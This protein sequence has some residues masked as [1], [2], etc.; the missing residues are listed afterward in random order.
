MVGMP[1]LFSFLATDSFVGGIVFSLGDV[2]NE[3]SV[4]SS[5]IG[6]ED[7]PREGNGVDF[8]FA[9]GAGSITVPGGP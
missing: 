3:E 6:E 8:K 1:L 4:C 5:G 7:S 2:S 9:G